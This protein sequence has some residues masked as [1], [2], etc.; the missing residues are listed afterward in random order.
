MYCSA[1]QHSF[2]AAN[3]QSLL[4]N[5]QR[6]SCIIALIVMSKYSG[7]M[8]LL[9]FFIPAVTTVVPIAERPSCKVDT[10][11]KGLTLPCMCRGL[12]QTR[13]HKQ[14]CNGRGKQRTAPKQK[15]N[16]L[17]REPYSKL[18]SRHR[19]FSI[20]PRTHRQTQ[21]CRSPSLHRLAWQLSHSRLRRCLVRRCM[22]RS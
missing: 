3:M 4:T 8:Q 20:T 1:H 2:A 21:H 18:H 6:T 15:H 17:A 10:A 12:K 16:R 22:W 7:G 14:S 11:A 5:Q 9:G 19:L 13:K